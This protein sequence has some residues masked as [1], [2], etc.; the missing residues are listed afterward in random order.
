MF[1]LILTWKPLRG[2]RPLFLRAVAPLVPL[3]MYCVI[4][5]VRI[6]THTHTHTP[7]QLKIKIVR[8]QQQKD[9]TG[10]HLNEIVG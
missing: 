8:F 4:S 1:M 10:S 6:S 2:A 7:V 5:Q 3:M 9:E